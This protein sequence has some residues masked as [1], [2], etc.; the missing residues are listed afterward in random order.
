MDIWFLYHEQNYDLDLVRYNGGTVPSTEYGSQCQQRWYKE[1]WQSDIW[2]HSGQAV[3][4]LTCQSAI[5]I[6]IWSGTESNKHN[7]TSRFRRLNF[8]PRPNIYRRGQGINEDPIVSRLIN[9]FFF[10]TKSYTQSW[11]NII[12]LTGPL[13]SNFL[14]EKKNCN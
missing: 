11:L 14:R 4:R 3:S 8:E 10:Q 12:A 5:Y 2:V 6:Q 7:W 1:R 9:T 13:E